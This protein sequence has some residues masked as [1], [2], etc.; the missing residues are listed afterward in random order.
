M[1]PEGAPQHGPAQQ[2]PLL[3]LPMVQKFVV[4]PEQQ[5]LGFEVEQQ[6]LAPV[7]GLVQQTWLFGQGAPP[8]HAQAPLRQSPLGQKIPQPPQL[9]RSVWV[10][11]QAPLQRV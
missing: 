6:I 8:E 1:R 10:L 2:V 5:Q 7:A 9:N 3:P 11:T 4:A